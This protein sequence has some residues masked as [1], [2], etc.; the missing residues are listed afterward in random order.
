MTWTPFTLPLPGQVTH[1]WKAPH[2]I[3][4]AVV[5]LS[6]PTSFSA[7]CPNPAHHTH[8]VSF[9]H[10]AIHI[11]MVSDSRRSQCPLELLKAGYA[12]EE[13][14]IRIV[15]HEIEYPRF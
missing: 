10:A 11:P 3:A 4:L 12:V 15:L 2:F 9:E 14:C 5:C 7:T 6:M 1:M 8:P 13:G